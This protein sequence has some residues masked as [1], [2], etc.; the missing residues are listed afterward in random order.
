MS[1]VG[2]AYVYFVGGGGNRR[3]NA[4]AFHTRRIATVLL[5]YY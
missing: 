1:I 2:N 4:G 3:L 5:F